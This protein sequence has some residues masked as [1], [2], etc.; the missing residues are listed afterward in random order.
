MERLSSKLSELGPAL[1]PYPRASLPLTQHNSLLHATHKST[2]L[3]LHINLRD[4][5]RARGAATQ[6]FLAARNQQ[7]VSGLAG[8][9]ARASSFRFSKT[10]SIADSRL[11]FFKES[12]ECRVSTQDQ[13]RTLQREALKQAENLLRRRIACLSFHYVGCQVRQSAT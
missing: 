4:S 8:T 13:N 1:T 2:Y 5:A 11:W 12:R 9:T 7:L 6:H 10:L 3:E